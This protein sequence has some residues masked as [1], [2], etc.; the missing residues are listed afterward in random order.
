MARDPSWTNDPNKRGLIYRPE[1]PEFAGP[2]EAFA[3]PQLSPSAR[4]G[5]RRRPTEPE[6]FDVEGPGRVQNSPWTNNPVDQV[7]RLQRRTPVGA[8]EGY[9]ITR[10]A[11]RNDL[12]Q[13]NPTP[14]SKPQTNPTPPSKPL[15][16][17]RAGI[18]VRNLAGE[19]VDSGVNAAKTAMFNPATAG[20]ADFFGGMFTGKDTPPAD[21]GPFVGPP[22][23]LAGPRPED[24]MGPS[25]AFAGPQLSG[26]GRGG[27]R[28]PKPVPAPVASS[29]AAPAGPDI[30]KVNYGG[31]DFF[32][33]VGKDG[34]PVFSN[35][36]GSD[37]LLHG[38]NAGSPMSQQ[39]GEFAKTNPAAAG[40]YTRDLSAGMKRSD[41][42]RAKEAEDAFQ[43]QLRLLRP[44]LDIMAGK[45]GADAESDRIRAQAAMVAAQRRGGDGGVP[46]ALGDARATVLQQIESQAVDPTKLGFDDPRDAVDFMTAMEAYNQIGDKVF[47]MPF[48]EN[49][50]SAVS[51]QAARTS[52]ADWSILPGDKRNLPFDNANTLQ[53]EDGQRPMID[54][55][56]LLVEPYNSGLNRGAF[57]GVPSGDGEHRYARFG[58]G[59][60][61]MYTGPRESA[62]LQAMGRFQQAQGGQQRGAQR[63]SN[64]PASQ[65]D[66][67]QSRDT[68]R[69]TGQDQMTPEEEAAYVREILGQ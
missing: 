34:V 32:T 45:A 23:A 16:M 39:F 30:R 43:Q 9:D 22:E 64:A 18:G 35:V 1:A 3:G 29:P 21:P 41:E 59:E 60:G 46:K 28:N 54:F 2:S 61:T 33:T 65:F 10:H 25:E 62:F 51:R 66:F 5:M 15:T 38:V 8:P 17:R 55:S 13:T 69:G 11:A 40:Q 47:E 12:S 44:D 57:V 27:P 52:A 53:F 68:W 67:G 56:Q 49:V 42:R 58:E 26:S 24:F 19:A 48:G 63:R 37:P 31:Q 20:V 7:R 6:V 4:S 36:S 50:M 14:P